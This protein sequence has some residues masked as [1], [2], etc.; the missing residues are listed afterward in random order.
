MSTI[1]F[2]DSWDRIECAH[3][4]YGQFL[5]EIDKT[6]HSQA[7]RMIRPPSPTN[8]DGVEIQLLH[9]KE[10]IELTNRPRVLAGQIAENLRSALDYIVFHLSERNDKTLNG[11]LPAFVI[12]DDAASFQQSSGTALKYLS[13]DQRKIVEDLQPYQGHEYMAVIRD[14]S[15]RS[16]HRSLLTLHN[17]TPTETVMDSAA[18]ANEYEGWWH[19]IQPNGQAIYVKRGDHDVSLLGK[20]NATVALKVSVRSDCPGEFMRRLTDLLPAGCSRAAVR[21]CG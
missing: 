16:K 18:N 13:A 21:R 9:P 7:Q 20:Y 11:R 17:F 2:Q 8:P 6:M 1:H 14:A 19:F 3:D 4:E 15:N 10:L 5:Y 12:A